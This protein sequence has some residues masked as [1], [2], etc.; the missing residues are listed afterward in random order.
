MIQV[1]V[2]NLILGGTGPI[3]LKWQ[4]CVQADAKF[5]YPIYRGGS[6]FSTDLNSPD[7]VVGPVRFDWGAATAAG[8]AEGMAGFLGFNAEPSGTGSPWS[9]TIEIWVLLTDPV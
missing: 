3:K 2:R 8:D 4:G 5:V 1:R 9:A 7:T 6:P